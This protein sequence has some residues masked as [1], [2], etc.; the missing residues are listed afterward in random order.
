[1]AGTKAGGRPGPRPR[2]WV[3]GLDPQRHKDYYRF[4][5]ARAQA[6]WRDEPWSLTFDQWLAVWGD[7]RATPGADGY[8]MIRWD[9]SRGWTPRNCR[10]MTRRQWRGTQQYRR[11]RFPAKYCEEAR[12]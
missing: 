4:L 8:I 7:L 5:R 1:M 3:T 10:V 11:Q 2:T 6:R 12:T 9:W